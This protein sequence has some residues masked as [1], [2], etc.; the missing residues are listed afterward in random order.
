MTDSLVGY[1]PGNSIYFDSVFV[2]STN[3]DSALYRLGFSFV[4]EGNGN[5]IPSTANVNGKVYEWIAPDVNGNYNGTYEPVV[6]LITPKKKQLITMG[7]ESKLKLFD[8]N[9]EL[10]ISNT[11]INTFSNLDSKDNIGYALKAGLFKKN[12]RLQNS[13]FNYAIN[14]E[15]NDKHFNPVE[16]YRSPEF[17]RDWNITNQQETYHQHFAN[18]YAG[19]N[20]KKI[21]KTNYS[22]SFIDQE[23]IYNAYRNQF[24]FDYNK[25]RS[26][27]F[28]NGSY[29]NTSN[30]QNTTSFY[31]HMAEVSKSLRVVKFGVINEVENNIWKDKNTDSLL[32]NAFAYSQWEFFVK[33]ADSLKS[34]YFVSYKYRQ[35]FLPSLSENK[36][37]NS[38]KGEDFMFGSDLLNKTGRTLKTTFSYRKLSILDTS[39]TNL[40]K[41]KSLLG[42]I[43]SN[44]RFYKG[45]INSSTLYEIGSGLESIKEYAFVEVDK[46]LGIYIWNDYN[47]NSI[48]ELE[49][50]EIASYKDT[51]NYL[52]VQLPGNYVKVYTTTF[53]QILNLR[54][55]K[56]W[57]KEKGVKKLLSR[58]SDQLAYR[59]SSKTRSGKII[60]NI[61]PFATQSIQN[62]IVTLAYS[63][64]NTV[65]FNRTNPIFGIDFMIHKNARKDLLLSGYNSRENMIKSLKIRWNI[66]QKISITEDIKTNKK[67]YE[68][69]AYSAKN[70]DLNEFGNVFGIS[71]QPTLSFRVLLTYNY[72]EKENIDS[73]K[74]IDKNYGAELKYNLASKRNLTFQFN[75]LNLDYNGETNSPLAYEML[76]GFLPGN[77]LT[78]TLQYQQKLANSLQLNV[79]YNGRKLPD[80]EALHSGGVQL[81]AFF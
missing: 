27:V 19:I 58:F 47:N 67:K 33:N 21:L 26:K 40:G 18:V 29:V 12:I 39:L 6:L 43:E 59:I 52:R 42:R 14:Y 60:E 24:S 77:N 76:Q 48:Q 5:Y 50:F 80:S 13:R 17:E 63:F 51:A 25:L 57:Y 11:D 79:S 2:Y 81:R 44:L 64:K 10:A 62:E 3:P 65:S 75:Y 8:I 53:N 35:D 61:N 36:L 68:S 23:K 66:N 73:E 34:N 38:S 37:L 1:D 71:Y 32:L 15:Y 74:A 46:G 9:Y 28:F 56:S 54:P 72:S 7:G 41:D 55:S 49:E 78:W 16:R 4:G 70:Y 22:L 45:S 30:I 31:R 69:E 20:Y